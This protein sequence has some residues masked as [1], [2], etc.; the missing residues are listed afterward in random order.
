MEKLTFPHKNSKLD[1]LGKILNENIYSFSL[2]SG[3]TCPGADECLAKV[4]KTAEGLRVKN[5]PNQKFRCFSASQE[6]LY[7]SVYKSRER[8]YH[9]LKES[10]TS[11]RMAELILAS[12]PKALK[13]CRIHVGG[14]FFSQNYFDAW[15]SVAKSKG[16]AKFYAYTKAL[17]FW[18]KRLGQ[19]P[20]NLKLTASWGGRYDSLIVPNNLTSAR[21]VFTEKQAEDLG[22][23]IDYTDLHAYE[24]KTFALLIHG[25][26]TKETISNGSK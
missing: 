8:N 9:M 17:P 15:I 13:V 5:G 3:W 4:I 6:A 1:K 18:I 12:L 7:T 16:D 26:Q 22:L 24:G 23:E 2:L 21:V 11:A 25:T 14:D 19:I 10:K 20:E